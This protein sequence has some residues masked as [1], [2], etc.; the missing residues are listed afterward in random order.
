MKTELTLQ[1]SPAGF[2]T[3]LL[4]RAQPLTI[5]RGEFS[6]REN[7]VAKIVV[8]EHIDS[9]EWTQGSRLDGK[10]LKADDFRTAVKMTISPEMWSLLVEIDEILDSIRSHKK[11][12]QIIAMLDGEGLLEQ[13]AQIKTLREKATKIGRNVRLHEDDGLTKFEM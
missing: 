1:F 2:G 4:L 3:N 8:P 11:A 5:F 6:L 10:G 13:H 12:W 9:G 7:V